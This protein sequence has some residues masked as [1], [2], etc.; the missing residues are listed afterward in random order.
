M[1]FEHILILCLLFLAPFT[2]INQS[3]NSI[4]LQQDVKFNSPAKTLSNTMIFSDVSI[5]SLW[6]QTNDPNNISS[7]MIDIS[8]TEFFFAH[9][10]TTSQNGVG[11]GV[12]NISTGIVW[13]QHR[14]IDK[15]SLLVTKNNH[16]IIVVANSLSPSSNDVYTIEQISFD[17]ANSSSI[18]WS[19][20]S[21]WIEA[22]AAHGDQIAVSGNFKGGVSFGSHSLS[23]RSGYA[24]A[25]GAYWTCYDTFAAVLSNMT[26]SMATK[27]QGGNCGWNSQ[28]TQ[29]ESPSIEMTNDSI[30]VQVRTQSQSTYT[31]GSFSG[32]NA[33]SGQMFIA[34][35]NSSTGSCKFASTA[36]SPSTSF[37]RDEYP[38]MFSSNESAIFSFEALQ[39]RVNWNNGSEEFLSNSNVTNARNQVVISDIDCLDDYCWVIGTLNTNIILNGTTFFATNGNPTMFVGKYNLTTE[40]WAYFNTAGGQS[41][42]EGIEIVPV[43]HGAI[44]SARVDPPVTFDSNSIV[45]GSADQPVVGRIIADSDFD[46]YHDVIDAFPQLYSQWDD[47]DGDG[48][49]DNQFGVNSDD[50]IFQPGNS[51]EDQDGCPD[52]DG[53]GYSDIGDSFPSDIWQWNDTDGDGFGDNNHQVSEGWITNFSGNNWDDCPNQHGS[54]TKDLSGCPDSDDDGYSDTSDDF[55]DDVTQWQDSDGDGFGDNPVGLGADSCIWIVG[56]ST[57]DRYGCIDS[58]G[59]GWSDDG[60]DLP[61]ESTQWKDRDGDGYGDNSAGVNPDSFPSDGT[62][63]NDTDEDGHGD[64]PYGTEGDWFPNDPARWQDS[65]R[66]GTADEDDAFPNERSQTNDSDGDGYGDNPD[67]D[68]PD[69]FPDNPEEWLDTDG[70]FVGN[71]EDAFPFDP[72]QSTDTDGDGFGDNPMGNG[73]D[74]FPNDETQ[75]MDIDGDGFGDNPLG[76]SPDAFITDPTQW[77]DTDG[78]GYGDNPTGRLA[79]AFIEDATQWIDVDGD[80]LGDNQSGNNPD[81]FLLD[82]DNDG[83]N[84]SIDPLPKLASPGDLD[85]DG[86]LDEEDMFPEDFREW[87]DNDDDGVGDNADTDDDNDGWSDADE[88]RDGTDPFSSSEQPVDSFEI[89]IPRTAVGLGAWDLI[90]IFGG[91]PLFI[92]IGF[93][94]ITRNGRTAKYEEKLRAANT[95]DELESVARQWEYSLMLRMLGPHQ[96]IRLERLRAE[97]DDVFER[98]NQTLSSLEQSEYNQTQLVQD[99]MNQNEKQ[100]PEINLKPDIAAV[101]NPDEKGYEWITSEDGKNWYRTQGSK[102]DWVEFSN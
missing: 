15:D 42:D 96:G 90:G 39:P 85:N 86:V 65:D 55:V 5:G 51:Y 62:Q 3:S 14:S 36:E 35:L 52:F 46:T 44:F 80:G 41:S 30:I 13:S 88:L 4:E 71:N 22:V 95:R 93:G 79:D 87:A 25:Y 81:P 18:T 26:W 2:Q 49:G 57:E 38:I 45:S 47:W 6:N 72:S 82:F 20:G 10:H 7:Y 60:D 34:L 53:D 19:A 37:D 24:A 9:H 23:S 66:D 28:H 61:Q 1:R 70:D 77:S 17:G 12:I 97:L 63:W 98:Q 75:W 48:F 94:F 50:C 56:N 91:V 43:E 16:S 68:N 101:G 92:W 74:R 29:W 32:C 83:Y 33:Q 76:T 21:G 100:V 54:S 27:S 78:D 31:G 11:I 8:P 89:V 102:D 69:A 73:A 64:N 58:D 67:G 40:T 84:D 99:E 59:D